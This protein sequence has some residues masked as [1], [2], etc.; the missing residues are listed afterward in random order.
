MITL[1]YG[2]H[3]FCQEHF[4]QFFEK[5]VR[6]VTRTHT[7][8]EEGE[9]IAVAVS[10]GK[11]SVV[12]LNLVRKIM[13]RH[14]LVGISIDEG[15]DGYRNKAIDEAVKNYQTLDMEYKIVHLK[16]EIGNSMQEIVQKTH[17]N[18]WNENSCTFCGVFRRKYINATAREMGADKL[19]TG[20]NLDDEVQSIAMNLFTSQVE[21]LSRM[22]PKIQFTKV[23]GWIPR[24]KPLYT[25]PEEEVELFAQLKQY[26]HYNEVCCPF[27]HGADRNIYRVMTDQLETRKPGSKFAMIQSFLKMKPILEKT[28]TRSTLHVCT[29]CGDLSSQKICQACNYETRLRETGELNHPLNPQQINAL[30]RQKQGNRLPILNG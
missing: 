20:H 16:K 23:K 5:R 2:P 29:R 24:V 8:F 12:A 4:E 9:K 10:G 14:E 1:P 18:K 25:S 15:I 30:K 13:P 22:G 3:T 6:D 27:S 19:V 21:R 11:D 26:P 7:F 17:E 28:D